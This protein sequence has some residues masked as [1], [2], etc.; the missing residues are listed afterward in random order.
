MIRRL[1]AA[2][3]MAA[4]VG[5]LTTQAQQPVPVKIDAKK[6]GETKPNEVG[7]PKLLIEDAATQQDRL[8]RQFEDFKQSLLRLA[9][10]LES[11]SRQE[12][13]DKAKVLRDAIKQA[14][15]EGIDTKFSSLVEALRDKD[16]FKNLEQLQ[17]VMEQN[18][19]L[20]NDIRKLIELLLKDDRDAE[21]RRQREETTRLLER[22]KEVIAKQGRVHAQTEIGR[23][24]AKDLRKEQDKVTKDTKN[25]IGDKEAKSGKDGKTGQPKEGKKG[26]PKDGKPKDGKSGEPKD[27]KPKDGKPKDGKSGEPKDG[28]PKDGKSGEPKDGKPKDGK[29]GEP[30]DGQPKDGQP[31]EGQQSPP[32]DQQQDSNP[33]RKQ[34]QDANKY[35]DK[36]GDDLDKNKKDSAS[37][38]QEEALKKLN[39]AKKK[40][41]DLLRQL[42]E[43]EIERLL[44]ALINRCN[45][46]L[47]MQ[48]AVRDGTVNLDKT[49]QANPMKQP[50]RVEEQASN[51]LSD[52]EEEIVREANT[53]IRLIEA[54]GSAVA[55]AEV[56]KQVRDD[57]GTV[58]GRLRKTDVG[59]VT[60][61]IE[62]Q[63][64][65]TLKEMIEAL[66]K[67]RQ[68]NQKPK[69]PPKPGQS[70]PRQDPL[71]DM[72]A[73]LKMIRSMQVRVNT[74]T[75]VYGKQY[76]GEQAP[77]PSIA[78]DAKQRDHFEMIQRELK[79]LSVRQ[80]KI[81]KVTDDIAKGKNEAK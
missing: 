48:I 40:L 81:S 14:S 58:A 77:P 54:E 22:L 6:K 66:K 30:K 34:I 19:D 16:A 8:K 36:A 61:T 21:L 26:E 29:G 53:A 51:V 27:G 17:T 35:Q 56:F 1:L 47:A 28:K 3:L 4:L 41:E 64:I 71:I 74:R 69:T 60:I 72:L 44:A 43:E 75:E 50:T 78:T 18:K 73:E 31:N 79:D 68:E 12:D 24:D 20:R 52:K 13:Q 63:I 76:E 62:N 55:F 15:D 70:G 7:D 9:Q 65:D 32:S 45:L 59:E 37:N 23:R 42:R 5:V 57:M 10:R 46:M 2:F 67:A 39:E 38:N 25:L 80:K 11:S 33:V 49:I